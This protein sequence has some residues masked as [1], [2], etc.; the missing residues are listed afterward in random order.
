MAIS[1]V[2]RSVVSG[3]FLAGA[4]AAAGCSSDDGKGS[5]GGGS[6]DGGTNPAP[7]SSS[8]SS[9]QTCTKGFVCIGSACRCTKEPKKDL[10]CCDPDDPKCEGDSKNCNTFCEVCS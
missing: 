1:K 6:G 7:T 3:L 8:T 4:F 2:F 10:A 9:Q 5:G